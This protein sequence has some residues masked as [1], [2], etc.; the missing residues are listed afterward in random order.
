MTFIWLF[1]LGNLKEVIKLCEFYGPFKL[2]SANPD[3]FSVTIIFGGENLQ[4]EIC[5]IWLHSTTA[6]YRCYF[7]L[8]WKNIY[9]YAESYGYCWEP[10][11]RSIQLHSNSCHGVVI[12]RFIFRWNFPGVRLPWECYDQSQKANWRHW[13]GTVSLSQKKRYTKN[14]PIWKNVLT[15]DLHVPA[16]R[17]LLLSNVGLVS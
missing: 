14:I 12:E 2:R 10:M 8:E 4:S 13:T 1:I 6:T 17:L 7:A 3:F 5:L 11:S 15:W 16:H 9:L